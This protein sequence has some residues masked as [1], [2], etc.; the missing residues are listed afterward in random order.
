MAK[1]MS[2]YFL[3]LYMVKKS[4][5]ELKKPSKRLIGFNLNH[6]TFPDSCCLTRLR[7]ACHSHPERRHIISVFWLLQFE[8]RLEAYASTNFK[9][10]DY[11]YINMFQH[12]LFSFHAMMATYDYFVLVFLYYLQSDQPNFNIFLFKGVLVFKGKTK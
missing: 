3:M 2:C 6:P 5:K 7:C 10:L 12:C 11:M 1:K 4:N 9:S 8:A